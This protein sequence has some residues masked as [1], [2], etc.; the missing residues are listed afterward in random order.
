MILCMNIIL[1]STICCAV[2]LYDLPIEEQIMFYVWPGQSKL[3]K[4]EID[5]KIKNK[6][7][8]V[9]PLTS[10]EKKI[11]DKIIAKSIY[12]SKEEDFTLAN[13]IVLKRQYAYLSSL[14]DQESFLP[15]LLGSSI[16][17]IVLMT[18]GLR[19]INYHEKKPDLFY[20][21][22]AQL[23]L[24]E[25]MTDGLIGGVSA[26]AFYVLSK[27]WDAYLDRKEEMR[28]IKSWLDWFDIQKREERVRSNSFDELIATIV[29]AGML[30]GYF[31][32]LLK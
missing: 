6:D 19:N 27:K 11:Y 15:Y 24:S 1:L 13:L 16:G 10:I 2:D 9:R 21:V 28:R 32:N 18:R 3:Y 12:D 7:L 23:G 4:N 14:N 17:P 31:A 30:I 8:I 25:L 26:G 20:P 22:G 29:G 5:E